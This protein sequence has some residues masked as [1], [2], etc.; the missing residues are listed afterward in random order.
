MKK[1]D[2]VRVGT[3]MHLNRECLGNPAGTVGVCYEVYRV[4]DRC[5]ASF[6]FQ[7][8]NN[9]GFSEDEVEQFLDADAF[10]PD[11]AGY[12]F[13][14]VNN[15]RRDFLAGLFKSVWP[16]QLICWNCG[17][18]RLK[19]VIQSEAAEYECRGCLASGDLEDFD[20]RFNKTLTGRA[21]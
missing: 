14:N 8:G 4:G 2:A 15:L 19:P 3:T 9:D 12:E 17:S 18:T 10:A 1:I 13:S 16:P 20:P 21:S 6:I 11:I 5:G 7:N